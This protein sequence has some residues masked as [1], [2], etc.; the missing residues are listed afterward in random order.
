MPIVWD[1]QIWWTQVRTIVFSAKNQVRTIVY[2]PGMTRIVHAAPSYWLVLNSHIWCPT[3]HPLGQ[4]EYYWT[5]RVNTCYKRWGH[6]PFCNCVIH[7]GHKVRRAFLYA[8]DHAARSSFYLL[9][10][11]IIYLCFSSMKKIWINN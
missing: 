6:A 11:N 1:D 5:R 10:F 7:N 8:I 2:K 4:Y 3:C 9:L